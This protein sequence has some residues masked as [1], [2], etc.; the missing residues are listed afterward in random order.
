MSIWPLSYLARLG[1]R[2]VSSVPLA[3]QSC[4]TV[5]T[6]RALCGSTVA[7]SDSEK[8]THHN[9]M[10]HMHAMQR[11]EHVG[12]CN[13][14]SC[15]EGFSLR[16]GV[17]WCGVVWCSLMCRHSC[18]IPYGYIVCALLCVVPLCFLCL[19]CLGSP[20]R[21]WNVGISREKESADPRAL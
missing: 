6:C 14:G 17:V 1:A 21:T 11:H 9:L 5:H 13:N 7:A 18:K 3:C 2:V 16:W 4:G 10:C 8:Q 19:E 12:C 15:A 20:E